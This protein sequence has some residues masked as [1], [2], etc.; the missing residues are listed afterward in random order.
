MVPSIDR[1]DTA[2]RRIRG[3]HEVAPDSYIRYSLNFHTY[4]CVPVAS[5]KTIR[6]GS[7]SSDKIGEIVG[8]NR[9]N[10]RTKSPILSSCLPLAAA[11]GARVRNQNDMKTRKAASRFAAPKTAVVLPQ[12]K[13]G[14][15]GRKDQTSRLPQS[16][17]GKD[18]VK[19]PSHPQPKKWEYQNLLI[20]VFP[21]HRIPHQTTKT[22]RSASAV[23]TG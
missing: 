20:P 1:R 13:K 22:Q 2:E 18:A 6:I 12:A 4:A 15:A 14:T 16:G 19:E 17:R 21:F 3:D 23:A 11:W 8:R 9:R 5:S 10:R 7:K